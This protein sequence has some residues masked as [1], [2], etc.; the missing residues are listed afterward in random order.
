MSD[1]DKLKRTKVNSKKD[2]GVPQPKI[3]RG[4]KSRITKDSIIPLG[5][6]EKL[7]RKHDA[8]MLLMNGE[9][10]QRIDVNDTALQF[11]GYSIEQIK[12]MKIGDIN[13]LPPAEL[14][15]EKQRAVREERKFF[16]VPHRLANGEIRTVEV[17]TT[18]IVISKNK[19]LFSVIN[20][21][22]EGK[23]AEAS[24]ALQGAI[25]ENMSEGVQLTRCADNIIVYANPIFEKMFGYRAGEMIGQDVSILNAPTSKAPEETARDIISATQNTGRWQGDLK[26]IKKDGTQFWCHASV[27]L[28]DHPEYGKVYVSIHTDITERKKNEARILEQQSLLEAFTESSRNPIFSIDKRYRYTSFNRV[29]AGVMKALY[30]VDIELGKPL[31]DYMTVKK[32]WLIAKA[33]LDKA[34]KGERITEESFSGDDALTRSYFTVTHDPIV[35]EGRGIVGVAIRALDITERRRLELEVARERD[36]AQKYLDVASVIILAMGP[37]GEIAMINK[38]GAE[39]L[40]YLVEEIIGKNWVDEYIPAA[41]RGATK[42]LLKDV[43]AGKTA[44]FSSFENEILTKDDSTRTISWSVSYILEDNSTVALMICSG[45]DITDHKRADK[46]KA[47]A[48]DQ[49]K[50]TLEGTV[51]ALSSVAEHRD[52]YTSGHQER[53]TKLACAIAEEMELS[54]EICEDIR[55][56]GRLHDIGK[57]EVPAEILSK[58]GRLTDVEFSMIRV[59]STIG[60]DIL[61]EAEFPCEV[62]KMVLSHH[63][64]MDGSGYPQGL[65]ADDI[66]IGAKIMAVADVVEAMSSHRPYRPSLGIDA[67]LEEIEKNRDKLYDP[68]VVDVCVKLF[69]EKGFKF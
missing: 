21:I 7:F 44:R 65:K 2:L 51:N 29:H 33:N 34:L 39:L 40:G 17:H 18:P 46:E 28:F 49:L 63:E 56:A 31:S 61:K 66:L 45:M 3:T 62:A 20:D 60:Y 36:M 16:I 68:D 52:P 53:V 54:P 57:I 32:D 26:N 48:Y 4:K 43:V 15:A 10:G 27:S 55:V 50:L 8:I 5:Q 47:K 11:Y 58:P 9:T 69:R 35:E 22:T 19:Y 42:Q 67:A 24:R 64:R 41:D 59:H 23:K 25:I 1:A 38:C 13:K 14:D 6:F 30:G 12:I 37:S